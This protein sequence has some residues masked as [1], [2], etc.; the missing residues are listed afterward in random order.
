VDDP[1]S[2]ILVTNDV[3][4]D[5]DGFWRKMAKHNN[6]GHTI[7]YRPICSDCLL[8]NKLSSIA[9]LLD[10]IYTNKPEICWHFPDR[11]AMATLKGDTYLSANEKDVQTGGAPCRCRVPVEKDTESENGDDGDVASALERTL[12]LDDLD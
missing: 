6:Q 2:Y 1:V 8:E 9:Q 7:H 12:N 11:N 4:W 3:H 5:T 10:P